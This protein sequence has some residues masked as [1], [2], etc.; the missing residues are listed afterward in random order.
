MLSSFLMIVQPKIGLALGS[1]GAKGLAHI[2]VLK[3][4]EKHNIPIHAIAGSSIGSLI[5]AHYAAY[6]DTK[7]LEELVFSFTRKAGFGLVD[8]T[9]SGGILKGN[10]V[11]T[12]I[13]T[14]L[15]GATFDKLKIPYA[16][17]ATNF[18]TADPVI[19]HSG[20]LSKAIRASIS[21]PAFFQPVKYKDTLLAD[22]G[23]SI[24]VPVDVLKKMQMDL[25]I[26]VNLDQVYINELTEKIPPLT[27]IPIH[28]VDILR[29]H[30]ALQSIK[31]ADV[32]IT[33]RIPYEIDLFGWNYF[34]DNDKAEAIIKS[35]EEAAEKIIPNLKKLL[36]GYGE[37]KKEKGR[38][39]RLFS[40]FWRR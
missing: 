11:E 7:R 33:P 17:V 25:V 37:V 28:S 1:G 13:G 19:L 21:I 22:G 39:Q 30:L 2:G 15:E 27:K 18:I 3:V 20:N 5:G 6:Q 23:L 10:K 38:L 8:L 29:H 36:A 9:L 26:G 31:T 14:M 40:L 34:F 35:G 4:F 12:F 24:P 16:A 32:I